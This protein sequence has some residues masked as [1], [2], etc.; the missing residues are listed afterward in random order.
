MT[1]VRP[2]PTPALLERAA[3]PIARI[4]VV[5]GLHLLAVGHDDPGGGF[6]GGLVIGACLAVHRLTSRPAIDRLP[7]ANARPILLAGIAIVAA[8]ALAPIATGRA[9]ADMGFATIDLGWFG[10]FKAT[11]ALVFDIGVVLVVVGLVLAM[12]DVATG[13]AEDGR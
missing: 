4:G 3:G 7:L 13:D 10:T 12:I 5:V 6:V 11:S 1:A 8:I 2:Q 9:L